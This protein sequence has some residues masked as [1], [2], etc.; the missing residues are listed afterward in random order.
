MVFAINMVVV[1]VVVVLLDVVV[2]LLV[3]VVSVGGVCSTFY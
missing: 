3:G 1:S 2:E